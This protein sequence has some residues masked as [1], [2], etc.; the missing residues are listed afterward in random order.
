[1]QS[2]SVSKNQNPNDFPLPVVWIVTYW[3]DDTFE[4][5]VV[6]PFCNKEAAIVAFDYFR[7]TRKHVCIDKCDVF[8]H[9]ETKAGA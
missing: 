4:E 9:F 3:T 1:M 2:E 7:L 8:K 6:T 5:P